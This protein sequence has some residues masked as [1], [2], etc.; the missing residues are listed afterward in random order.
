MARSRTTKT[1][2]KRIDLGYFRHG[3]PL[4]WWRRVLTWSVGLVA[5]ALMLAA[6]VRFTNGKPRMND[7]IHNPGRVSSAHAS[8]END[9]RQCHTPD[10][11]G[12]FRLTVSDESCLK[13]HDG[14]I[15]H[16]NQKMA[17]EADLVSRDK[18]LLALKDANHKGG[19]RA[20]GCFTC[21]LEHRGNELL[22]ATSDAHCIVCHQDLTD[23]TI[24]PPKTASTVLAFDAVSHPGFGR[25]LQKGGTTWVDPTVLR[26][27][28][29]KH[30]TKVK[31]LVDDPQSCARCHVPDPTDR[32]YMMPVN[33]E[34][35]CRSCH[36]MELVLQTTPL[37]HGSM[38]EVRDQLRDLDGLNLRGL[39]VMSAEERTRALTE[40]DR[41][42]R[43]EKTITEQEWMTK[44]VEEMNKAAKDWLEGDEPKKLPEAA[45]AVASAATQPSASG[46]IDP[47]RALEV[48]AAYLIA[49]SCAYCHQV[50]PGTSPGSLL[51]K[52]TGIGTTPRR[53]FAAS[54][55][56]HDSHRNVSCKDCHFGAATS[57]DTSDVLMPNINTAAVGAK[58]CVDCHHSG[59]ALRARGAPASCVTCHSFHDRTY[60]SPRHLATSQPVASQ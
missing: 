19:G 10:S 7:V 15:H 33:Y 55:F 42:T 37:V 60:E 34:R 48:Y 4:R 51:T 56:N 45:R 53:W 46:A 31:E 2:A 23:T 16:S 59:G 52:P 36:P 30:L 24:E 20:A 18:R 28:H 58:T 39:R 17:A 12:A 25:K 50:D 40:R 1:I 21:H 44:R 38:A 14:P 6:S 43:R 54:S 5:L 8:F 57:K 47:A 49:Y 41:R 26:F 11:D 13:C 9:C 3:H 35:H 22:S 32:Q 29:E 27:N